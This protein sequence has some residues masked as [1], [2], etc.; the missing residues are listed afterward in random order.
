MRTK[1]IDFEVH[2]KIEKERRG[3]RRK[4]PI[5]MQFRIDEPLTTAQ[6]TNGSVVAGGDFF[7][8]TTWSSKGHRIPSLSFFK[9]NSAT[10]A[11]AGGTGGRLV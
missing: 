1:E 7:Y 8:R 6:M 11:T 5:D 4:S 9:R 2:H 3:F 10:I